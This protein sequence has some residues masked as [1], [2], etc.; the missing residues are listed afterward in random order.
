MTSL[1]HLET[2]DVISV[3]MDEA[4]RVTESGIVVDEDTAIATKEGRRTATVY[5]APEFYTLVRNRNEK[6]IEI[7]TP[8]PVKAGDRVLLHRMSG[9]GFT[10]VDGQQVTLVRMSE[11]LAV[12]DE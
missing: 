11:V 5:S 2:G 4:E 10:E 7:K 3:I 8:C 6:R 1:T 12:V 9:V